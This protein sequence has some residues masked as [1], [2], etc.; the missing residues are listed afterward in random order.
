MSTL[1]EKVVAV[2]AEI[3]GDMSLVEKVDDNTRLIEDLGLDSIQI[4]NLI[5][6]TEEKLD[7]EVDINSLDFSHLK[8]L[9]TFCDFLSMDKVCS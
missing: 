4:I 3:K 2:I 7:I 8:T 9:R 1:N 6:E 5:M